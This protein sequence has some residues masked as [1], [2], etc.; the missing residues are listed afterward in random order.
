MSLHILTKR[1]GAIEFGVLD[2]D[3]IRRMSVTAIITADTYDE[4][5]MPIRSGLMDRRLGT[6]EPGVRCETCGNPVGLCPGHFGHI[7]LA[8][9][10]IHVGFVKIIHQLLRATCRNC[11]RLL[12]PQSEIEKYNERMK[13]YEKRWYALSLKLAEVI[14]KKA[15]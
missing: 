5:G 4:D 11:G 2:P 9:P 13:R 1:I 6:V 12:L 3:T 15:M 8:R 14:L 10:V 7:E